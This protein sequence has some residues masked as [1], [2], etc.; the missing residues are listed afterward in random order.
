MAGPSSA[1]NARTGAVQLPVI[2]RASLIPRRAAH[3]PSVLRPIVSPGAFGSTGKSV[4]EK[5][6]SGASTVDTQGKPVFSARMGAANVT[7]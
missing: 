4:T 3:G 6:E 1:L 7:G 2:P 5:N